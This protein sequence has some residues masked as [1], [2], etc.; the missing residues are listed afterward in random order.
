MSR[1]ITFNIFRYDPQ[2]SQDKPK[3]ERYELTETDGMTV[4]IA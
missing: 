1:K 4:F 2:D 3:M